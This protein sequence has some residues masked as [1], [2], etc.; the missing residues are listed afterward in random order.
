MTCCLCSRDRN[1]YDPACLTCGGRSLRDIQ[2]Q[3]IASDKKLA[4]LRKALADWM[5][6]GHPEA[7]LRD[8]AK[9]KPGTP[10]LRSGTPNSRP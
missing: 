6:H 4:W 1:Q 5:A 8:L 3:R 2:R 10:P 7:K 9:G